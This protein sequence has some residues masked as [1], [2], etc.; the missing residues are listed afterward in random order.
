M[1]IYITHVAAT[2]GDYFATI[3]RLS[4]GNFRHDDAEVFESGLALPQKDITL[5]EGASE[6]AGSYTGVVQSTTWDDGLYLLR[7]HDR[8]DVSSGV[9]GTRQFGVLQG[10]EVQVGD[11]E[12][13]YHADI[14]FTKG[15][16]VDEYTATWFKNGTIL[17][18]G[19]TNPTL[20]VIKRTDGT[21]LVPQTGMDEIGSSHNFKYDATTSSTRQTLGENYIVLAEANIDDEARSFSWILGRDTDDSEGGTGGDLI[22]TTG[23]SFDTGNGDLS[24]SRLNSTTIS[25]NFDGRY[26][27]VDDYDPGQTNIYTTGASFNTDS[28]ILTLFSNSG[29]DVTVTLDGRYSTDDEI[30]VTTGTFNSSTNLLTI[31]R[32]TGEDININL[33]SLAIS[34]QGTDD[35][36]SS[37][38]FNVLNGVLTLTRASGDT[39]TTDLDGR[40]IQIGDIVSED[41]L[42]N[43]GS[44]TAKLASNDTL[45][46]QGSGYTFVDLNNV[47]KTFTIGTNLPD[48][49][50]VSTGSFNQ[51]T[52]LL[53]FSRTSGDDITINLAALATTGQGT[54]DHVVAA[55]FGTGNGVLTL[56]LASGDTVTTDLDGRWILSSATLFEVDRDGDNF[57]IQYG[58]T[59]SFSGGKDIEVGIDAGTET[60]SIS[61]TGLDDSVTG[62]SF[63]QTNGVLTLLR[64][65]GSDVTVDLDGRYLTDIE[66]QDILFSDGSQTSKVGANDTFVWQ[67]SGGVDVSL[68][69]ETFT[70][71][72]AATDSVTGIDFNTGNGVLTLFRNTGSDLTQSLNGRYIQTLNITDD[73]GNDA[74]F[75]WSDLMRFV[76]GSGIKTTIQNGVTQYF[77]IIIDN[78]YVP[79]TGVS[80]SAGQFIF[81]TPTGNITGFDLDGRYA[82]QGSDLFNILT[83]ENPDDNGITTIALDDE[84]D[85]R[86]SGSVEVALVGSAGQYILYIG[87]S[88]S[89]AGGAGDGT[90]VGGGSPDQIAYWTSSSGLTG[91]EYFTFETG[92]GSTIV[93]EAL[94]GQTG[95][96]LELLDETDNT[97]LALTP[98]G[99]II[100]SDGSTQTGAFNDF[101]VSDGSA[102]LRMGDGSTLNFVSSGETTVAVSG[103]NLVI[104]SE[105]VGTLIGGGQADQ[106]AYWSSS[107]GLTGSAAFTA[108]SAA[109]TTLSV[110][111]Q[112]G[113]TQNLQEWQDYIS[114][115]LAYID[116][117][118]NFS[119]NN[120]IFGDGTVQT[121]AYT[122]Q[123]GGGSPAGTLIGGG[124]P[125]QVAYWSSASGLTGSN[126][127]A[128]DNSSYTQIVL[129]AQSGQTENIFEAQDYQSGM[130]ASINPTGG[131]SGSSF[132][133]GDGT[134]QTTAAVGGGGGSNTYVSTGSFETGNVFGGGELTLVRTSG[135]DIKIDL[136]GRYHRINDAVV[137]VFD[138]NG[139]EKDV[140]GGDELYLVGN[141][142]VDV[143]LDPGT[144]TFTVSYTGVAGGGGV[145]SLNGGGTSGQLAYWINGTGLTGNSS[146]IFED[147]NAQT[148]LIVNSVSG[149][150]D[151]IIEGQD[152]QSGLLFAVDSSGRV[153]SN[154]ATP[155]SVAYWNSDKKL[156]GDSAF[157]AQSSA[158][159]TLTVGGQ[160]GQAEN[161]QE[162]QDYTSG[163]LAYVDATGGISGQHFVFGDGTIQTT[164][165]TGQVGGGG[166]DVYVSTGSFA[167]VGKDLTLTRTSGND[168][169][170]PLTGAWIEQGAE[171]FTVYDQQ[172]APLD[173]EVEEGSILTFSGSGGIEVE[174]IPLSSTVVIKYTG[175][176][177]TGG[178][179]PEQD[180]PIGGGGLANQVT[181]WTDSTTVTGSND[182]TFTVGT[183]NV[184]QIRS[185]G[186]QTQ[187][188][189]E[190]ADA[191]GEVSYYVDTSGNISGNQLTFGDGT[192]QTTAYTGGAG[193]GGTLDGGG[194]SGQL[195]Y[196]VSSIGLTG[197]NFLTFEENSSQ[198]TFVVNAVSGQIDN[199]VEVQDYQSGVLFAVDNSGKVFSEN[200]A[201]NSVAYWDSNKKLT[202]G[203]AFTAESA[204]YAQLVVTT[205]SGQTENL[206][207]WQSS[208]SGVVASV[209]VEGNIS[210]QTIGLNYA[211]VTSDH[212]IASN[213]QGAF[214]D[215][216]GGSIV[217]TL[218]TSGLYRGRKVE[219]IRMDESA[220]TL[221]VS[222]DSTLI[223][224]SSGTDN[225]AT[226]SSSA[227][228]Y[229]APLNRWYKQ[230]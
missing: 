213:E 209:D 124:T 98:T 116:V 127:F 27:L 101:F 100:F 134:I 143:N 152:Y 151:N 208:D 68:D 153:Y 230:Y 144:N 139:E 117:S 1:N 166:S 161:L 38:S 190:I 89:G 192:T 48:D 86:G 15:T 77:D 91:N 33:S 42:L 112:S 126:G 13:I 60:I 140:F 104:G 64:S 108:Q 189:L 229:Q 156:V 21:D 157:T 220:N 115:N 170:I 142:G 3:E 16:L 137:T 46:W 175:V 28:G 221:T 226:L 178:S 50:Y 99:S 129:N 174:N 9:V 191:K 205:Q 82:T 176:A 22:Y 120:I 97:V 179:G 148:T 145:G 186:T 136:D 212:T 193:G 41:I 87:S 155:N 24:L 183:D 171:L 215:C 114:G 133:F 113:Q 58:D 147:A 96:M 188:V 118:G 76:G 35:Y 110:A 196:W 29:A 182:L 207:E 23:L 168:I 128:L 81:N 201:A 225:V 34:G 54:D 10:H 138:G 146:L 20:R 39:V 19:V 180:T 11:Q 199:I 169:V 141:N 206:Q 123:A 159:T 57:E 95:H 5:L 65:T 218:P 111:G 181:Y 216:S 63:N 67:G 154:S 165:Y 80:F 62:A 88:A 177:S 26:L 71:S 4:D 25:T 92:V 228:I 84:I 18:T 122:G 12:A 184:L 75:L 7:V 103:S 43:D 214:V 173:F 198:T 59:L 185:K 44:T 105:A 32:N 56:T 222:G 83:S 52:N 109:Y 150:S 94:S 106:V 102:T 85:I 194:I 69:G 167:S 203:T 132:T 51:S 49:V 227:Y 61:Y 31:V 8:N 131:F 200:I 17:T 30:Y 125:Q 107:S 195:A 72:S 130:Q 2:G 211:N 70:I 78:E 90:L 74:D 47:T 224:N 163:T 53:T 217:L 160:S 149:Q 187:P 121:T 172:S 37:A 73:A 6:N 162:W 40:Y 93:V 79:V 66:S 204:G 119:G 135:D 158:Y 14:N 219:V 210:G 45:T 36:V 202:G 223:G 197:N 55:S 164:A